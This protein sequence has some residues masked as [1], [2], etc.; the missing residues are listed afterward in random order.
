MNF[1]SAGEKAESGP[2]EFNTAYTYFF[3]SACLVIKTGWR[4]CTTQ[5]MIYKLY[6]S[7][8]KRVVNSVSH[9]KCRS[10]LSFTKP[11]SILLLTVV[12]MI[13]GKSYA[14]GFTDVTANQF[15]DLPGFAM[16]ATAW[17]GL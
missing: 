17:G 12:V 5:L 13:S 8:M 4:R 3:E 9:V 6:P 15:E 10:F 11:C 1:F 2:Q 7:S 16:G 14:Q